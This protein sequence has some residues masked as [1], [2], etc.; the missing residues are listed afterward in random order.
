MLEWKTQNT[1]RKKLKIGGKLTGKTKKKPQSLAPRIL[2]SNVNEKMKLK[3]GIKT[4]GQKPFVFQKKQPKIRRKDASSTPANHVT[5][6]VIR[7]LK[8]HIYINTRSDEATPRS[9]Q[10]V[11][12]RHVALAAWNDTPS[13]KTKRR[14]ENIDQS[15]DG[16]WHSLLKRR[17]FIKSKKL[18]KRRFEHIDQ[19]HVDTC[20]PP[21]EMTSPHLMKSTPRKMRKIT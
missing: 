21:P 3:I 12:W 10:S 15:N 13:L 9:R 17:P 16:T 11:A 1:N 20:Q 2:F 19:S 7:R 18:T 8:R 14:L 6:R 4:L 5:T